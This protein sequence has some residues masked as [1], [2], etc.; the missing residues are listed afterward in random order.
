MNLA[1]A[2]PDGL[3]TELAATA[4]LGAIAMQGVRRLAPT[5]GETILVI[6]L[7][8][9]GQITT[10]LL[11][12]N[13]CI[14]IGTD[15]DRR[16]VEIALKNGTDHGLV[17]E[18]RVARRERFQ[19][20]NGYGADGVI[21]T[22]A[23][24]SSEVIGE[25]FRSCRRKA[26]VVLVGDVGLQIDRNDMYA[27]NWISSSLRP[28]ALAD[29]TRPTKMEGKIIR[30]PMSVGPKIATCR[31]TCDFS[32]PGLLNLTNLP[33]ET[34]TVYEAPAAYERLKGGGKAIAGCAAL[35]PP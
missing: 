27:R 14:V 30:C 32:G 1:A 22:A 12:A 11:K 19:L 17:P 18:R 35:S 15:V 31:N 21:I 34:Y 6:G 20:S 33:T 25:A 9:L 3:A 5:L 23:T 16:R 24:P 2:V 29:M 10:Q 13:G 7:G 26:R 28:M 8:I 4:T